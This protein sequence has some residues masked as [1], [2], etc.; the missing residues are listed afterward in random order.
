MRLATTQQSSRSSPPVVSPPTE[1]LS[2]PGSVRAA[3][4]SDSWT[5]LDKFYDDSSEE[6]ET[7]S[8]ASDVD[9]ETGSHEEYE[10]GTGVDDRSSA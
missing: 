8:E 9:R 2:A 5:D 4:F 1:E 6:N 3:G 7:E 10:E